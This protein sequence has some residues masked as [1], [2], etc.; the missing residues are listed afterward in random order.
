MAEKE[1]APKKES[2]AK[3]IKAYK[4]GKQCPKCGRR[5]AEH[6]NRFSCGKCGYA[7]FKI[8]EKKV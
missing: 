4:P 2:K 5:M 6:A 3:K 1:A 8:Q 7:E